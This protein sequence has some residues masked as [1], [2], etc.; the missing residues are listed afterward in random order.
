MIETPPRN[1]QEQL[2]RASANVAAQ[3]EAGIKAMIQ[4]CEKEF[5]PPT[6]LVQA[7]RVIQQLRRRRDVEEQKAIDAEQRLAQFQQVVANDCHAA[8]TGQLDRDDSPLIRVAKQIMSL[9]HALTR[10]SDE[11]RAFGEGVRSTMID[12]GMAELP[13]ISGYFAGATPLYRAAEAGAVFVNATDRSVRE[14]YLRRRG[15]VMA[16]N[17]EGVAW[18]NPDGTQMLP[19]DAALAR[20][21]KADCEP[22][23]PMAARGHVPPKF[24]KAESLPM[25]AD[26]ATD[27]E[28]AMD[29][30]PPVAPIRMHP[31]VAAV[32]KTRTH[33]SEPIWT[34][35]I[36]SFS[37]QPEMTLLG[38]TP[39]ESFIPEMLPNQLPAAP[40]VTN[41]PTLDFRAGNTFIRPVPQN[42]A[43]LMSGHI[44]RYPGRPQK[45]IVNSITTPL[46]SA[47][48]LGVR[49]S[50]E[51]IVMP[52]LGGG[53]AGEE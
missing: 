22:F 35:E 48:P 26:A 30:L 2:A 20:Q 53:N 19:L 38:P 21:V 8:A 43:H 23:K 32:A 3:N 52:S 46:P 49:S 18:R 5:E 4:A 51:E 29:V 42:D 10:M 27:H 11:N 9:S 50:A 37:T 13:G 44:E 36:N 31:D 34:G 40:K 12:R 39:M 41:P 45:T 33:S 16:S 47:P 6:N 25:V 7:A 24:S 17:G 28:D 1:A 15:W 14:A